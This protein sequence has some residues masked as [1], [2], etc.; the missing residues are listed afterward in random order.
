MA[1]FDITF[2]RRKMLAGGLVAGLGAGTVAMA[3]QGKTDQKTGS[4]AEAPVSFEYA[5][6]N[7][8][9]EASSEIEMAFDGRFCIHARHC[10]T[11]LTKVF[12]TGQDPWMDPAGEDP[13]L[14]AAVIEMCPSGALQYK[15]LDGQ[16][17][18]EPPN[19]VVVM[20]ENGPYEFR[21][22]LQID[23]REV[24]YRRTLCRCGQS[25]NKPY[26]DN[27]HMEA[28]V[29]AGVRE[30]VADD[31]E[32]ARLD[33][34]AAPRGPLTVQSSEDGPLVVSGNVQVVCG[35]NA[36]IA[37]CKQA[38]LCSCGKSANKPFCDGSH[39]G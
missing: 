22:T 31:D 15:R 11:R 8:G 9:S 28:F 17:Q 5:K 6:K 30:P 18:E 3:S 25:Q 29:A 12:R 14:V 24:G 10:H 33:W 7:A 19:N 2:S 35:T 1:E 27:S 37:Y 20:R 34:L 36:T 4:A 32:P 13:D 23:G 21:G 39:L 26:C 38:S 16:R